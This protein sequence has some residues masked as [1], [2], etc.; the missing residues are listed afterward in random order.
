MLKRGGQ[1]I[2]II[3]KNLEILARLADRHFVLERG[4]VCWHGDL[5][6]LRSEYNTVRRYVGL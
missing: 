3:D 2:L 1:S 6:A 5:G 4:R